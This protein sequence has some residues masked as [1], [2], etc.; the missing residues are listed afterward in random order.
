MKQDARD[1]YHRGIGRTQDSCQL[2]STR[3]LT[4]SMERPRNPSHN[5][6]SAMSILMPFGRFLY[7]G[8]NS[9]NIA[10]WIV[11]PAASEPLIVTKKLLLLFD[12]LYDG[13]SSSAI[14]FQIVWLPLI[15]VEFD[16][17]TPPAEDS[18]PNVSFP[19]KVDELG[20]R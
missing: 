8:G 9:E 14:C 19:A 4:V 15:V 2:A 13:V 11:S 17:N 7:V 12:A 6:T 5:P 10:K 18:R 3:P 16:A 1:Y 20:K